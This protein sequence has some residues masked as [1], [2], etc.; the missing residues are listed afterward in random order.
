MQLITRV[1]VEFLKERR[2]DKQDCDEPLFKDEIDRIYYAYRQCYTHNPMKV[3]SLTAKNKVELIEDFR[4]YLIWRSSRTGVKVTETN[5]DQFISEKYGDIV[6][7]DIFMDYLRKCKFISEHSE[8]QSPLEHGSLTVRITGFSRAASMQH[9]RHRLQSISQASQRYISENDPELVIPA[10]IRANHQA[11]EI[12]LEYLDQL[13][14]VI[15]KLKECGIPTEDIRSIYP[16][17]MA[18]EEVVTMNFRAWM[19]YIE[20]RAC[21]R[22]QSEIRQVARQVQQYLLTEI[23]FVFK[24]CGPKCVRLGYCPEAKS[25]GK[26]PTKDQVLGAWTGLSAPRKKM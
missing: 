4:K 3:K 12:W 16:N 17:A 20:E 18:T 14:D 6:N 11:R 24:E 1:Q 5:V 10:T 2:P 9:N 7:N 23:P 13:P 8:H 22:A 25:C 19:H 26:Y 15:S 21:S